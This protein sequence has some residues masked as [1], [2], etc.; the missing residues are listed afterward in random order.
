MT[1]VPGW[2]ASAISD[3]V[4]RICFAIRHF[5]FRHLVFLVEFRPFLAN[6]LIATKLN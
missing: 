2:S 3:F 6:V 4:I 1:K 5:K